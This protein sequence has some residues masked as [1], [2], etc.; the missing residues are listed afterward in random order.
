MLNYNS[1][2]RKMF[3]GGMLA[4]LLLIS[5][6]TQPAVGQEP[7]E[8]KRAMEL[9][10]AQNFVAALPLF[11]QFAVTQPDNPQVL[12]R[13]GFSLYAVA[14]TE[15]DVDRR[16]KML[17]RAREILLKSRA[18]GDDSN[19]TQITLDGLAGDA[20]LINFSQTKAA[21]AAMR[22]GEGAFV[23]GDLDA[24][25]ASY[26][27]ALELDPRLYGA[28]VFA[29][30]TE[31]KKAYLSKD[32]QFRKEH[33]EQAAG[34]F[35]KAIAID[36]NR[37]TAYRYWGDALNLQGKAAE[38]RDKF[39]DAIVAE[40]YTRK[41]Y[42]GLTQWADGQK[43]AMAHPTIVVPAGVSSSKPGEVNVTVDD[44]AL[45]GS[46]KDGTAAWIMY[47][48]IRASWVRN[49][50]PVSEKFSKA[51]PGEAQYR[52]SLAEEVEALRVVA[53]SAALQLKEKKVSEL[54]PSLANLIRLKEAGLLEAYVLFAKVDEG[55]ARDYAVYRSA[56]RDKLRRYWLEV[57]IPKN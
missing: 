50:N 43:I 17:E 42:V 18:R 9:Y 52:H 37:E 16:K 15:K 27:R 5:C 22:E 41:S 49:K 48:L 31:F 56:N 12:S 55:I 3:A 25:L 8:W 21:D 4:A 29:G 47:G 39:V 46:E 34:W 24:A 30:D 45:K 11:E 38:A 57:V 53:E 19:L 40:P 33:F 7:P 23:R 10:E 32:A 28:A 36:P 35:A 1:F 2:T 26:K 54:N 6:F 13:L 51:Y 44:Q 14:T 20:A